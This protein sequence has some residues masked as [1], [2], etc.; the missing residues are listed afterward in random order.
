MRPENCPIRRTMAMILDPVMPE[1]QQQHEL[2]GPHIFSLIVN[3]SA[4]GWCWDGTK[5]TSHRTGTAA[6]GYQKLSQ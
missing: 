4:A 6:D 2:T 1:K 3:I 5:V